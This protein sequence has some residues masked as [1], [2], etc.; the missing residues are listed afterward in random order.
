MPHDS[1]LWAPHVIAANGQYYMFY[2]SGGPGIFGV[3]EDGTKYGISLATSPDLSNWTPQGQ[4]FRDG[5]QARDPM[6]MWNPF[7]GLWIMYYCATEQATGGHH[8]VVCRTSS[9]LRTWSDDTRKIAYVDAH[10]GK[11]FG[12]TESPFVVRRGDFYYLFIGPRP[13]DPPTSLRPNWRHQGY[14]GTDIFR[15]RHWDNWTDL[16]YI[17]HVQAHAAEV[18]RDVNGDW[19][20]SHAGMCRAGL[21]LIPLN[22]RDGLDNEESS[23]EIPLI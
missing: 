2:C 13:Y 23:L 9:D 21:Y 4:L 20:V 17:V 16:D 6:V 1:V 11:E 14:D 12:P 18:V 15:S 22:W 19:Y 5:Y 8:V 7:L 3:N 10:E